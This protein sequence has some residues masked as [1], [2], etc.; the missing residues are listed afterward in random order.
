[1]NQSDLFKLDFYLIIFCLVIIF[2]SYFAAH[3]IWELYNAKITLLSYEI[4]MKVYWELDPNFFFLL[5]P[6]EC[7]CLSPCNDKKILKKKSIKIEDKGFLLLRLFLF[8]LIK[9]PFCGTLI[10]SHPELYHMYLLDLMLRRR[11]WRRSLVKGNERTMTGVDRHRPLEQ[12]NLFDV[13]ISSLTQT[14]L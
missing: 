11:K 1:M 8:I 4:K 5:H 14:K 7:V 3:D 2:S 12:L 13:K 10:L 9:S 6:S